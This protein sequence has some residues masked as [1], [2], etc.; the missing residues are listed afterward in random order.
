MRPLYS[1]SRPDSCTPCTDL[2]GLQPRSVRKSSP[3]SQY[4][5]LSLQ[6]MCG[7]NYSCPHRRSACP[8]ITYNNDRPD[9]YTRMEIHDSESSH[10]DMAIR[11]HL[12]LFHHVEPRIRFKTPH[13]M[14]TCASQT[15][16]LTCFFL[17]CVSGISNVERATLHIL[18]NSRRITHTLDV[19]QTSTPLHILRRSPCQNYKTTGS[20][21]WPSYRGNR[22]TLLKKAGR[23]YAVYGHGQ[24]GQASLGMTAHRV[25]EV[26]RMS[27]MAYGPF[28]CL[29][30]SQSFSDSRQ[31][32]L[33][34]IHTY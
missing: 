32:N 8:H 14:W 20:W 31:C 23:P 25:C 4:A 26:Y 5:S 10:G 15:H 28:S 9:G 18:F 24:H 29:H 7:C 34:Y 1:R 17:P 6:A 30:S 21:Q 27:I 16:P 13:S 3:S 22:F 19:D 33:R 11:V 2:F 12:L